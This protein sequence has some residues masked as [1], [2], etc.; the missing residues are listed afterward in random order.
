MCTCIHVQ[1]CYRNTHTKERD[2]EKKDRVI[3]KKYWFRSV[4]GFAVVL[5]LDLI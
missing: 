5:T 4:G 3:K 1:H 2:G